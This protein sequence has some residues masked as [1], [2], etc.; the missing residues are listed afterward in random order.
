MLFGKGEVV[1][2]GSSRRLRQ[3]RIF[4]LDL[5]VRVGHR[6][7]ALVDNA[8]GQSRRD[9][10]GPGPPSPTAETRPPPNCTRTGHEW[11]TYAPP[12]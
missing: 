7:A 10:S 4:L 8:S 1:G 9:S 2:A 6:R 12:F 11:K 5:D 3:P